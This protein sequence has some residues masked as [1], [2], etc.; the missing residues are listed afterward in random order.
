M[1]NIESYQ[2]IQLSIYELALNSAAA[3]Y[4]I[5]KNQLNSFE[6]DFIFAP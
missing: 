6:N 1:F 5:R 4:K 2:F 3:E